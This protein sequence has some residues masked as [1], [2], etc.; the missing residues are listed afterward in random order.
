MLGKTIEDSPEE[1]QN[2]CSFFYGTK[3]VDLV[4]PAILYQELGYYS[5]QLLT[6]PALCKLPR[7]S[8]SDLILSASVLVSGRE[9][10]ML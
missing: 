8:D 3:N 6:S 10:L 7:D 5:A 2:G 9:Q 4:L 1:C